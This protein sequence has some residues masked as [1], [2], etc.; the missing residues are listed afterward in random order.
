MR[1]F[2]LCLALAALAAPLGAQ[3]AAPAATPAA[4]PVH[5][6]RLYEPWSLRLAPEVRASIPDTRADSI[7]LTNAT[8]TILLVPRRDVI[9]IDSLTSVTPRNVRVKGGIRRGVIAGAVV[10]VVLGYLSYQDSGDGLTTSR[11]ANV[12]LFG[13]SGAVLGGIIGGVSG[14]TRSGEQWQQLW[15]NEQTGTSG[16]R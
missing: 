7:P 1:P 13:A 4:A 11:G 16:S 12:A 6:I 9:S 2:V 10:G 14:A 8:G 15:S 3:D 5:R